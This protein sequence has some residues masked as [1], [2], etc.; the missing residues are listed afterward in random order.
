[1]LTSRIHGA[2][3]LVLLSLAAPE[4]AA[5]NSE[6]S[7]FIGEWRNAVSWTRGIVRIK[8]ERTNSRF[9]VHVWGRCH[10]SPCDWDEVV[11]DV[12]VAQTTWKPVALRTEY[13]QSDGTKTQLYLRIDDA[14]GRLRA[15]TYTDFLDS[16]QAYWAAYFLTRGAQ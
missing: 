5:Q 8:I 9:F 13:K 2:V 7:P 12:F 1:M 4:A 15:E 14:T 6:S 11:A 16:R 3:L 10:P